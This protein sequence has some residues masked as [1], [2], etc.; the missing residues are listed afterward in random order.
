MIDRAILFCLKNRQ[1][2][3]ILLIIV[4]V[5]TLV[6]TMLPPGQMGGSKIFSYD[7]S[8][9]FLIFFGWT[10]LY[11]LFMFTKKR[12]ETKFLLIFLA[13]CFFGIAIEILQEILPFGRTMDPY[14][15]LVDI[16][17][18]IVAIGILLLIKR[19]YLSR[20]IEKQLKKI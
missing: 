13:G 7:K 3:K 17:G 11:G 19:R 10:L 16:C 4:T 15:A 5:L 9:H 8:G 20:E 18:S 12:T 2:L 1:L 14:D 6:L